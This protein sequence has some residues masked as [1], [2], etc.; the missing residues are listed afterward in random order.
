MKKLS[1]LVIAILISF[2]FSYVQINYGIVSIAP[3][4]YFSDF[5][6][7]ENSF[8]NYF[9]PSIFT[10][11]FSFIMLKIFFY[12]KDAIKWKFL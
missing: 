9:Y 7:L 5:L 11:L 3:N 6:P 12:K 2:M 10:L 1:T 8:M 4:I